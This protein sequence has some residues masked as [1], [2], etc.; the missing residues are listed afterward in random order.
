MSY[1]LEALKKSKEE[2]LSEDAP[3]LHVVHQPPSVKPP[4]FLGSRTGI[5]AAVLTVL[6]AIA[7]LM[8]LIWLNDRPV[9]YEK[10][11]GKISISKLE[12]RGSF[13]ESGGDGEVVVENYQAKPKVARLST[14]R[15]KKI[16]LGPSGKQLPDRQEPHNSAAY[17]QDLPVDVQKRLP[18]LVFAGHTY[19]DDPSRRMIIVNNSI[20]KEGDSID[21]ETRLLGIIWEGVVLDHKGIIYKERTH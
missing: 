21:A 3:H 19:S 2:R 16:I 15:V 11:H 13:S 18:E 9:S 6:L 10:G 7:G 17:R 4:L 14:T 8:Y 5:V 1:I 20:V 12:V